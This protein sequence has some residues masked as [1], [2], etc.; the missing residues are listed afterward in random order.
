MSHKSYPRVAR[1]N[2]IVQEVIADTLEE[3]DDDNL[4]MVTVTSCDV[5]PDLRHAKVFISTL[6]D[7][8]KKQ[9]ALDALERNKGRIKRAM[10]ESIRMKYL[11]D[12]HFMPD[13]ATETGWSIETIINDVHSRAGAS[14]LR[15]D[16]LDDSIE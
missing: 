1:V 14:S 9:R 7:D 3:L 8:D 4:E 10:S 6:G 11:P 13:P 16:S 5:S 12:L 15:S 2:H